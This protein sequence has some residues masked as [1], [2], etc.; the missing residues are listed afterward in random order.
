MQIKL[1]DVR[2]HKDLTIDLPQKGLVYLA[3]ASGRGKTTIFD[4]I[5]DALYDTGSDIQPWSGGSPSIDITIEELDLRIVKKRNPGSL[6]VFH[7]NNTYLDAEAQAVIDRLIGMR[8]DEFVACSYIRQEGAGSLLSLT[9]AEQ[10]RFIQKISCNGFDPDVFKSVLNQEANELNNKVNG[11]K[12]ELSQTEQTIQNH[13]HYVEET[14]REPTKPLKAKPKDTERSILCDSIDMAEN[15]TVRLKK[16]LSSNAADLLSSARVQRDYQQEKVAEASLS[17][18]DRLSHAPAALDVAAAEA[19]IKDKEATAT[20]ASGYWV[21]FEKAKWHGTAVRTEMGF[22]EG[23]RVMDELSKWQAEISTRLDTLRD[24]KQTLDQEIASLT[25]SLTAHE[26]PWCAEPLAIAANKILKGS[27]N[28]E[29]INKDLA[30]KAKEVQDITSQVSDLTKELHLATN[31]M[32]ELKQSLANIS[33]EKK[34][35]ISAPQAHA[36]LEE[37]AKEKGA[38]AKEVIRRQEFSAQCAALRG[39][40]TRAEADLKS[41][42]ASIAAMELDKRP[43]REEL[44]LALSSANEEYIKLS[45]EL[46]V[47]DAA[48]AEWK[49]YDSNNSNYLKLKKIFDDSL[50]IVNKNNARKADLE[51]EVNATNAEMVAADRLI[52]LANIAATSAIEG[53]IE[54][55]N[56]NSQYYIDK[57][58]DG[59]GTSIVLTNTSKTKKGEER[60]KIGLDIFHKGQRAKKLANFSGGEKARVRLAFQLGLSK[61]F[62]S[63]FLCLDESL[64]GLGEDDKNIC[65]ELLKECADNRLLV[66]IE[67]GISEAAFDQVINI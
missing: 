17:L 49:L 62:N 58:F 44:T 12:S 60:A 25:K 27:P 64:N 32:S 23:S 11:L 20:S 3:G 65:L 54:E 34:P 14:P 33:K 55:I 42:E 7:N 48:T 67:H 57:F 46:G 47:M 66:V 26:C 1:T 36:L 8:A 51:L 52:E 31:H 39:A 13:R 30:V 10:L 5:E 38:L 43:S 40:V 15:K 24:E 9:P 59:D 18:R 41:T 4:A 50:A 19:G 45:Q 35:T 22:P 37:A 29:S 56:S 16:E 2:Q 61:L 53:I 28:Q 63:P 6:T 21:A